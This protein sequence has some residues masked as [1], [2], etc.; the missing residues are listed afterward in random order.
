MNNIGNI[1]GYRLFQMSYDMDGE[2]VM[3]GVSY[4]PYGI[5]ITY[6]GYLLLLI[7]I[8]ATLFSRKTQMRLL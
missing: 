4:D 1:D 2:G 7:G 5:A 3:L 8:L 6:L